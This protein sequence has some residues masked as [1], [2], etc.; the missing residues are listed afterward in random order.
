M[1]MYIILPHV[2]VTIHQLTG[3]LQFAVPVDKPPY[4]YTQ[5][6]ESAEGHGAQQLHILS[7]VLY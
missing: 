4:P 6:L 3:C 5:L 2:Y 7:V 1:L